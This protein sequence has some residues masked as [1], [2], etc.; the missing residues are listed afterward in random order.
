MLVSATSIHRRDPLPGVFDLESS[1]A[2]LPGLIWSKLMYANGSA[3]VGNIKY[4]IFSEPLELFAGLS[5]IFT[6]IHSPPTGWRT[7]YV[8][9]N[10]SKPIGLT[11]PHS[12][13]I[14]IGAQTTG[15]KKVKELFLLD[16]GTGKGPE[17][18]WKACPV[19]ENIEQGTW[20]IYWDGGK[21]GLGKEC[22]KVEL[23]VGEIK[24]C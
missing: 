17:G 14:P 15:F 23:K 9:A 12:G 13:F 3:Y 18:R 21:K 22:I 10:E 1:K 5:N 4:S 8:Y 11:T 2:G 6:S 16:R 20:G 19:P 7:F 24:K